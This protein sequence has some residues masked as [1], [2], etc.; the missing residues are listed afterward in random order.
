MSASTYNPPLIITMDLEIAYDHVFEQQV[1]I[2]DRLADDLSRQGIPMT[3]F[4][5]S[6][7]TRL[8]SEKIKTLSLHGH[9]IGCHGK[10]HAGF[11]NFET[12]DY[13]TC[14]KIIVESTSV[15]ESITG[16]TPRS[17]R[18]PRME[19]S[20]ATQRALIECGYCSDYS[21]SSRRIY[22]PP[23]IPLFFAPQT[24][25]FSSE[26]SHLKPGNLP[27]LNVPL[28]SA[29][30]PFLSGIL[31]ILGLSATKALF[32]FYYHL[33]QIQQRPI[34][35]LFHS[36]EGTDDLSMEELLV[37]RASNPYF[38]NKPSR[39]KIYRFTPEQKYQLNLSLIR[40]MS[41]YGNTRPMTAANFFNEYCAQK[42][43]L[44]LVS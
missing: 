23:R 29:G 39:Q 13:A 28:T 36:Y 21:V 38:S 14:K 37:S 4:T 11:E 30:I 43:S 32:R 18:G 1:S 20:R 41:G 12:M 15:L 33:C 6:E 42:Q 35:Y 34:V 7:S 8:F 22:F 19:T 24:P 16:I 27:L 9:E 26:Q 17:F 25:Y 5:T 40:Y 3:V 2:L 10:T 31:Y 44:P